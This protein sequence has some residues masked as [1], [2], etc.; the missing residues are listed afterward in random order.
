MN[1]KY[2]N[3]YEEELNLTEWPYMIQTE[4]LFDYVTSYEAINTHISGGKILNFYRNVTEKPLSIAIYATSQEE[5]T[6]ALNR[7]YEV[8]EK[9]VLVQSPGRMVLDNGQYLSCYIINS[10]NVKWSQAIRTSIKGITLVIEYPYWCRDLLSEY[11]S[12]NSSS[13]PYDSEYLDYPY[14]YPYDLAPTS[15]GK[16][17]VNDHFGTCNFEMRI[18]G[19]VTNPKVTIGSIAYEVLCTV[20]TDEF[21]IINSKDKTVI[22]HKPDGTRVNEFNNRVGEIFSPIPPG[23]LLVNKGAVLELDIILFEERS[24]PIWIL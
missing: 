24:E 23:K 8:V 12:D 20:Y 9:D 6:E 18:Y 11:R 17:L 1:V 22:R 19:P 14:D 10:E 2:V 7:F 3:S 16:Y 13:E 5:F 15:A 4:N 21:L